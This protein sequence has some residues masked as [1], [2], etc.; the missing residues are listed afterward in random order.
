GLAVIKPAYINPV[1]ADSPPV[2]TGKIQNSL[3]RA[4]RFNLLLH[5]LQRFSAVQLNLAAI[6]SL[7]LEQQLSAY[8]AALRQ[9]RGYEADVRNRVFV[10]GRQVLETLA[11]NSPLRRNRTVAK[12]IEATS[13]TDFEDDYEILYRACQALLPL[14]E[15]SI[16]DALEA[17]AS[18]DE[19]TYEAAN[20]IYPLRKAPTFTSRPDAEGYFTFTAAVE[21]PERPRFDRRPRRRLEPVIAAPVIDADGDI[22]IPDRPPLHPDAAAAGNPRQEA[23]LVDHSSAATPRRYNQPSSSAPCSSV[24]PPVTDIAP[25][26]TQV[27]LLQDFGVIPRPSTTTTRAVSPAASVRSGS[28]LGLSAL[29]LDTASPPPTS[30]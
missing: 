20:L 14:L 1:D 19:L 28:S 21:L 10:A 2:L 5:V 30:T 9:A 11:A 12:F 8:R 13:P 22:A 25:E 6:E 23:P 27:S 24:A 16:D 3:T 17:H 29:T 26:D 18:G 15:A 7:P 4:Q